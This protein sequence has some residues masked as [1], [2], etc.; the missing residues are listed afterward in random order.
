VKK[1]KPVKPQGKN[2]GPRGDTKVWSQ[3]QPGQLEGKPEPKVTHLMPNRK[4]K[5]KEKLNRVGNF[6]W[7]SPMVKWGVQKKKGGRGPLF[8]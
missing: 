7:H 6:G 5:K 8:F 3:I 4:K 1:K 2:W